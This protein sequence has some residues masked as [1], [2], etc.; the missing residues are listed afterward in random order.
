MTKLI[1]CNLAVLLAERNLKISELSKRTGIS[2]TTLTSL[3]QN[4]SKGIQFDTFDTLCNYL[5][6]SPNDLFTQEKFEYDFSVIEIIKLKF[7][8]EYELIL[9][10]EIEYKTQKYEVKFNCNCEI[11]DNETEPHSISVKIHYP[12]EILQIF[13]TIPVIFKTY[14]EAELLECVK[15]ELVAHCNL[16]E[17][18]SIF[19]W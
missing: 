6:I 11:I 13:K 2:R 14:F 18:V 5:K 1:K 12:E 19:S 10:T 4:Q 9:H 15:A 16:D 7:D 3:A 17:D 8:Y